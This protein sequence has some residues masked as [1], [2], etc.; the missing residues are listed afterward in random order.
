MAA[1]MKANE[2]TYT[3]STNKDETWKNLSSMEEIKAEISAL[4]QEEVYRWAV[5]WKWEH[6]SK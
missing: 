2:A 1:S 5:G 4:A 3:N 6:I